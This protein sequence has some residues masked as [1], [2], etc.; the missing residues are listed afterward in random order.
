MDD[1]KFWTTSVALLRRV[2]NVLDRVLLARGLEQK[3][4]GDAGWTAPATTQTFI[5]LTFTTV[6]NVVITLPEAKLQRYRVTLANVVAAAGGNNGTAPVPL[7]LLESMV[8]QF[9]FA[10]RASM[11]ARAISTE[12]HTLVVGARRSGAQT[13]ALTLPVWDDLLNFWLKLLVGTP[14][15]PAWDG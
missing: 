8:G 1:V 3:P 9:D 15:D 12:M 13:V 11:W 6:P 4:E 14:N 2:R 7:A 5:G 10:G